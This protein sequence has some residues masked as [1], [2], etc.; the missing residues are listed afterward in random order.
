MLAGTSVTAWCW[1]VRIA[2]PM[3]GWRAAGPHGCRRRTAST[4]HAAN[5]GHGHGRPAV[6]ERRG[7]ASRPGSR[8][9]GSADMVGDLG[10]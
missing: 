9:A 6:T 1:Q 7:P 2:N 10:R 8:D 4:W 3:A 5:T